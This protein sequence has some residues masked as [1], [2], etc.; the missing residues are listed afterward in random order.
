MITNVSLLTLYV[1][2]QD[3]SKAFYVDKLGFAEGTDVTIGNGFRWVTITHPDHPELEVVLALPGPPMDDA[4]SEA[5]RRAL[6]NGTMGGFGLN[7]DDCRKE[8]ERLSGLGVEFV[9][10]PADRPYGVEAVLRDNSGNW[11]VM[12]EPKPFDATGF[13]DF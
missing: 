9:Q 6:A 5:I 8:Y 2:D 13:P 3:E 1:A 10:P 12:T 11:L 4:V 7:T